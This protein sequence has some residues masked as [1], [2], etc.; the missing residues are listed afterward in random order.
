MKNILGNVNLCYFVLQCKFKINYKLV[1][2][3]PITMKSFSQSYNDAS[4]HLQ[5]LTLWITVSWRD[6]RPNY[7][8]EFTVQVQLRYGYQ[9]VIHKQS[10]VSLLFSAGRQLDFTG[11]KKFLNWNFYIKKRLSSRWCNQTAQS[12]LTVGEF[13]QYPVSNETPDYSYFWYHLPSFTV[14]KFNQC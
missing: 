8:N 5:R 11:R 1:S 10:E 2:S 3:K 6:T 7:R 9:W 14:F 4:N 12:G 13:S